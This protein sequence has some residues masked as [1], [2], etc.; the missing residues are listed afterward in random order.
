MIFCLLGVANL[1]LLVE[2]ASRRRGRGQKESDPWWGTHTDPQRP[3]TEKQRYK[4]AEGRRLKNSPVTHRQATEPGPRTWRGGGTGGGRGPLVT[5]N[6]DKVKGGPA[7]CP[8]PPLA[9]SPGSP[10]GSP[11]SSSSEVIDLE[12]REMAGGGSRL[13]CWDAGKV[14]MGGRCQCCR[15]KTPRHPFLSLCFQNSENSTRAC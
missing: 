15:E 4:R 5:N 9:L 7:P 13:A 12:R 11:I 8:W 6:T 2:R 14:G 10:T 3:G 1:P